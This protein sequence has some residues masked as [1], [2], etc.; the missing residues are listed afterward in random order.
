MNIL[1]DAFYD[2]NYG[3]DLFI[4]TVTGLFPECKFYSFGEYYPS[5]V[6][7]CANR[8]TNLFL[9][10]ECDVFLEKNMFDAYLCVGGDVFPD[11]AD[12]TKRKKYI[13]SVKQVHGAVVFWGF[14][15]FRDY[16]LCTKQDIIEM[17]QDADIIAPRDEMSSELLRHWLPEKSIETIAD[18]AFLSRWLQKDTGSATGILGISVRHPNY[19]TDQDMQRYVEKLQEVINT[20]LNG[21]RERRVTL[22]SLSNGKT[23]DTDVAE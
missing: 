18:T 16:S 11:N 4:E 2:L 23:C 22:F 20:Y 1:L 13:K 14:S 15:L 3:D 6:I 17:M 10:P 9:L 19:A 7:A 8:I 12:Y 5:D 21:N